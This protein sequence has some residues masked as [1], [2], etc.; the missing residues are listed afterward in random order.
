VENVENRGFG[1]LI[2]TAHDLFTFTVAT[3]DFILKHGNGMD[4]SILTEI[5]SSV[6]LLSLL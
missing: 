2:R 5:S 1:L 6:N 3:V 4:E